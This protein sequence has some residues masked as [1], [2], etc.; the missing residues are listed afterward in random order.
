[1]ALE[2]FAG[3]F[4]IGQRGFTVNDVGR[5]LEQDPPELAGRTQG[6]EPGEKT[7]ED[8]GAKLLRRPV[9]ASTFIS[10]NGVAEVGGSCSA[11]TGWRV[12]TPNAFTW[13]TN[14]AGVRSAQ[15]AA[16]SGSGKR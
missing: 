8:L 9:D 14:P 5:E 15:R 1:M 16:S 3:P 11:L 12:M 13:K 4:E 7:C 6:L 2:L 10:L